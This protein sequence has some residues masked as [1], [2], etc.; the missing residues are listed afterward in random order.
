MGGEI[1]SKRDPCI[2]VMLIVV[3]GEGTKKV[4]R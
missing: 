2:L 1:R 4:R 3:L